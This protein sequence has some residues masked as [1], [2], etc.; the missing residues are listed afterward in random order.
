MQLSTNKAVCQACEYERVSN[1]LVRY[2]SKRPRVV[3]S[4]R[5]REAQLNGL[6]SHAFPQSFLHELA[7]V[8]EPIDDCHAA[9]DSL[10]LRVH[11]PIGFEQ[12][13]L[14]VDSFAQ[15]FVQ[16]LSQR[17]VIP[18]R[19]CPFVLGKNLKVGIARIGQAHLH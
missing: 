1:V 11:P 3:A 14:V 4:T 16:L 15:L 17:V 12:T 5:I 13:E 9:S 10:I 6:L 2:D 7:G 8:A 18:Q 19:P